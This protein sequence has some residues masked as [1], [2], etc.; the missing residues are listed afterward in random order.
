MTAPKRIT[1]FAGHYGSGKTLIAL[2]YALALQEQG[3]P[4][5][6]ADLDIVN[7]YFRTQD[8][9]TLLGSRGIRLIVSEYAGSNAELPGFPPEAVSVFDNEGSYGVL[10][11][12]GDDRGALAL[13]R[14][15]KRLE[16]AENLLVINAF[17][18]QTRQPEGVLE[19]MREMED[20]ARMRFTGLVNNSHWGGKTTLQDVLDTEGYAAEVSRLSGLPLCFTAIKSDLAKQWPQEKGPCLPLTIYE[21]F[22]GQRDGELI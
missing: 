2:N 22:Q 11:V 3:L 9:K 1:V 7:P 17:R 13:G 19:L 8:F 20:A 18:P 15:S 16:Q 6:L 21:Q 14:F 4:V 10:D 5:T 12:G